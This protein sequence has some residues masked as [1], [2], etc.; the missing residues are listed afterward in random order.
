M[1]RPEFVNETLESKK[2][3]TGIDDPVLIHKKTGL[4]FLIKIESG[5]GF[6]TKNEQGKYIWKGKG[7]IRSPSPTSTTSPTSTDPEAAIKSPKS[8]YEQFSVKPTSAAAAPKNTTTPKVANVQE[9]VRSSAGALS[10]EKPFTERILAFIRTKADEEGQKTGQIS[11]MQK[12]FTIM[13]EYF[14]IKDKIEDPV[15]IKDP[16]RVQLYN[17]VENRFKIT[18]KIVQ[19]M[20]ENFI[21]NGDPIDI[22]R[23]FTTNLSDRIV[24]KTKKFSD[25]LDDLAASVEGEEAKKEVQQ[26]VD[27]IKTAGQT[28]PD[29][30]NALSSEGV[31]NKLDIDTDSQ[32]ILRKYYPYL[33]GYL[34][35]GW[36][37]TTETWA[38]IP[39]EY[40]SKAAKAT[41][42]ALSDVWELLAKTPGWLKSFFTKSESTTSGTE[43]PP[44]GTE[45]PPSPKQGGGGSANRIR[46]TRR[47]RSI[48][49][50]GRTRRN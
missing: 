38:T 20:P 26:T 40:V 6:I 13:K 31:V 29:I 24:D 1:V 18:K 43:T 41:G 8:P 25:L 45:I 23:I 2:D 42:D 14:D 16:I 49:L 44:S 7:R 46:Y 37:M 30:E 5:E 34:H 47:R 10:F 48:P 9:P 17:I 21:Y 39:A 28:N 22:E 50:S 19:M 36:F 33:V 12:P 35:T 32:N 3:I 4:P 15:I 11:N 27:K